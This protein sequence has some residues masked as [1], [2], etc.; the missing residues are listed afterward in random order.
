MINTVKQFLNLKSF[1]PALRLRFIFARLMP[2][3]ATKNSPPRADILASGRG[4]CRHPISAAFSAIPMRLGL[5]RNKNPEP[6][7]FGICGFRL[8]LSRKIFGNLKNLFAVVADGLTGQDSIASVQRAVSSSLEG[9][10][11]TNAQPESLIS[12]RPSAVEV[13]K[14]QPMHWEST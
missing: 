2:V 10:L 3:S 14:A 6:K 7:R 11:A 1:F 12:K 5:R 8:C 13:H 4:F 9:C